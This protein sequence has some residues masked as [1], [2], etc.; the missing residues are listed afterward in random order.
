MFPD[1]REVLQAL[2]DRGHK[3]AILSN[4]INEAITSN[5]KQ[6]NLLS[7]FDLI[8]GIDQ[9]KKPKPNR[10]GIDLIKKM[11]NVEKCI[12]IGD[13]KTDMATAINAGIDG[14]GVGWAL[15]SKEDLLAAG[16]KYVA[17]DMKDLLKIVRDNYV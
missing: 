7:F 15:T 12:Y 17:S 4:K 14:I 5:L 10:E 16:A 13:T 8:I 9:V 3:M 1:T 6:M 2:K 11:L